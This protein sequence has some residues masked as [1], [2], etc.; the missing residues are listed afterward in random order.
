[1]D[2]VD[3]AI[4]QA[5]MVDLLMSIAQNLNMMASTLVEDTMVRSLY[6]LTLEDT[7]GPVVMLKW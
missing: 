6:T 1:M 3:A 4:T 7:N 2:A 5:H